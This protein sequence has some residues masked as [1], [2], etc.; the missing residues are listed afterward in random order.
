MRIVRIRD[1]DDSRVSAYLAVQDPEL[2]RARGLF[3]AEG[4]L[5]VE[6]LI[7]EG[8]YA[9]QSILLSE[10][11]FSALEPTLSA[12]EGP[13]RQ[14]P[15]DVPIYVCQSSDLRRLTGSHI[16]GRHAARAVRAVGGSRGRLTGG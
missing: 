5:V 9:I 15:I 10:A 13:V 7:G 11:A 16:D 3:V 12:F 1:L 4:Q 2:V 14:A 8:R 6:R